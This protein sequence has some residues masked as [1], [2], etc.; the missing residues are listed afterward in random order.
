MWS[1]TPLEKCMQTLSA[2]VRLDD[3]EGLDLMEAAVADLL[4]A[5][6]SASEARIAALDVLA[7]TVRR[8]GG[9]RCLRG[10]SWRTSP[11]S[12]TVWLA[13]RGS[14]VTAS[15]AARSRRNTREPWCQHR[16]GSLE[17]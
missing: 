9:L 6:G 2:F 4:E 10:I 12:G 8:Q 16:P 17:I 3:L 7:E 14:S 1:M 15:F 5:A 11:S 13:R